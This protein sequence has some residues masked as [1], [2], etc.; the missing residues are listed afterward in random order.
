MHS[1]TVIFSTFFLSFCNEVISYMVSTV[2]KEKCSV[3]IFKIR[4]ENIFLHQNYLGFLKLSKKSLENFPF[5]LYSVQDARCGS[6]G[7]FSPIREYSSTAKNRRKWA[8]VHRHVGVKGLIHL[9][10]FHAINSKN[11]KEHQ[12]T[13]GIRYYAVLVLVIILAQYNL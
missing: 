12:R 5:L 11:G 7:K 4:F 8:T 10:L 6:R 1:C 2:K 3:Y 13:L 9:L